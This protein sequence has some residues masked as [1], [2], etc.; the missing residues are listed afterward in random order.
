MGSGISSAGAPAVLTRR[1]KPRPSPG[2]LHRGVQAGSWPLCAISGAHSTGS[3]AT[4]KTSYRATC[5]FPNLNTSTNFGVNP[6]EAFWKRLAHVHEVQ[7]VYRNTQD[8]VKDDGDLARVRSGHR[9]PKTDHC[10]HTGGIRRYGACFMCFI[11]DIITSSLL[12]W[13]LSAVVL[14]DVKMFRLLTFLVLHHLWKQFSF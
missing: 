13:L 3:P 6:L 2:P 10:N 4:R 9:V 8:C 11:N 1:G 12:N 7:D 5:K 14:N